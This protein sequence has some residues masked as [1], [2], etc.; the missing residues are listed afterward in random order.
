[1]LLITIESGLLAYV[2]LACGF[3]TSPAWGA[4]SCY[5]APGADSVTVWFQVKIICQICT[6]L[7]QI[8]WLVPWGGR[9]L[10]PPTFMGG[11]VAAPWRGWSP[12]EWRSKGAL[13][14]HTGKV[15]IWPIA[16]WP[17]HLPLKCWYLYDGLLRMKL[18]RFL[19]RKQSSNPEF[20][21][22]MNYMVVFCMYNQS[23]AHH[24]MMPLE[25][26]DYISDVLTSP[27]SPP[28]KKGPSFPYLANKQHK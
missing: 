12:L 2:E 15:T 6:W 17:T 22:H 10:D 23:W 7:A 28:T 9:N 24:C 26:F 1:M 5:A 4:P 14:G 16:A 3:A 8:C 11:G 19:F 20:A 21:L 25:C 13:Y 27:S 18:L